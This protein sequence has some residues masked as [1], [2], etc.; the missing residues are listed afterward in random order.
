MKIDFTKYKIKNI[1]EEIK[2][3][4]SNWKNIDGY[5]HYKIN[6]DGQVK[7]LKDY[8]IDCNGIEHLVKEKILR[9]KI[10]KNG[11]ISVTLSEYGIRKGFFIH[12][13]L[14]KA[15]ISNP[16]NLPCVNHIDENPS[17]NKLN[18]LEWVTYS[19]NAKHSIKRIIKSH[20]K[21]MIPVYSI[22]PKTKNIIKYIGIRDAARKVNGHHTNINVAIKRKSI[23]Y[24]YFWSK[25]YPTNIE[26]YTIE[27]LQ[28]RKILNK[29]NTLGLSG[30]LRINIYSKE[31]E[32]LNTL[33]ECAKIANVNS[34][35]TIIRHL[36]NNKPLKG[37]LYYRIN[38]YNTN[39]K[40]IDDYCNKFKNKL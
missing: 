10:N 37:Y 16:N 34:Q 3:T 32:Y 26:D 22:N 18:N 1:K 4:N 40:D 29:H 14:A 11:Y 13:L 2:E 35:T 7:R 30:I 27:S 38:Y 8:I 20:E 23:A 24:G 21:E 19:Q 28:N 25:E 17:N 36:N 5:P 12:N 31:I 39:K 33:K 9:T 15:F 6:E